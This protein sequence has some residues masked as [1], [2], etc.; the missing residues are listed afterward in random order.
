[1]GWSSYDLSRVKKEAEIRSGSKCDLSAITA[2]GYGKSQKVD[3]RHNKLCLLTFIYN[4]R[5][6]PFIRPNDQNF[7]CLR[8]NDETHRQPDIWVFKIY[9]CKRPNFVYVYRRDVRITREGL[10]NHEPKASDLQAFRVF[11]QHPKWVITPVNP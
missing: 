3:T 1:M 9:L 11:S 7:D 5:K 6:L 4:Q 8:P 2:R 10:V